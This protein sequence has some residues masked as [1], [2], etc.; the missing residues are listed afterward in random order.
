[1]LA[2]GEV[3]TT[4]YTCHNVMGVATLLSSCIKFSELER[5]TIA[6]NVF[7]SLILVCYEALQL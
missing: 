4:T 3:A 5:Y 1:M 7:D 6:L 2:D